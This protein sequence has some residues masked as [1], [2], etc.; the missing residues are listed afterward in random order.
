MTI[1]KK[2]RDKI[3]TMILLGT[4]V[5]FATTG[6]K[7]WVVQTFGYS[8]RLIIIGLAIILFAAWRWDI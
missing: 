6:I 2:E 1:T 8:Y 5:F 4:G 7:D 3:V